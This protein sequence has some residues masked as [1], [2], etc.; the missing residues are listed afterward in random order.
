[1]S[2]WP[3]ASL[4]EV[5]EVNPRSNGAEL[6]PADTEVS[7]VPMAAV[8]ELNGRI[9]SAQIRRVGEVTKGYTR[10]RD[11]DVLFAK[12]TPCM[13]NGKVA[14]AC[15]LTQGVGF[16][17][18]EFH[19]LRPGPSVL[20]RWVLACLRRPAF[21]EAAKANFTGTAGQRRVPTNFLRETHIPLPPLDEQRRLLEIL[22]E[23]EALREL[24]RGSNTRVARLYESLYIELF[25]RHGDRSQWPV[26]T[27]ESLL[28]EGPN[29]IRT[30]PFGS[31]LRHGEFIDTGLPV[32]GIDNV[33]SNRFRW[34]ESRCLPQE[35]FEEFRRFEVF[36]GDLLITIMGTVGRCCVA[37]S[38]LPRCISTKHLCVLTLA[39]ELVDSTFVWGALL[40]DP[41]LRGQTS[42]AGGGAIMRGW[43][44][45]IIRQLRLRLPP[46]ALQKTFV[47]GVGDV[48]GIEELQAA[49][50]EHLDDLFLSVL[51]RSVGGV[52]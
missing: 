25:F 48:C 37:P 5:C 27:I 2:R 12:I 4:S 10:F 33:V 28:S 6:L 36:P 23:V 35:R 15:D 18:T 47:D 45:T 40:F 43:N 50:C 32:L 34:G 22:A 44:S 52:L 41:E 46:L 8:D 38:D 26:R 51:D 20:S 7:F 13:E 30:G 14:V 21:R 39:P 16:G 9:G 29:R 1:M 17:S 11:G 49:K 3:T 42:G 24:A 31:Q 19:V